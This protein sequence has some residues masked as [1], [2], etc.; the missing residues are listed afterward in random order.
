MNETIKNNNNNE[1]MKKVN[2]KNKNGN[3]NGNV[4]VNKNKNKNVNVNG[5]GKKTNNE[6]NNGKNNNSS[7]HIIEIFSLEGCGYSMAAEK[8]LLEHNIPFR[9]ISVSQEDKE[10]HKKLNEMDTFPQIFLNKLHNKRSKIGGYTDLNKYIEVI[11][12]LCEMD[13][14]KKDTIDHLIHLHQF[15]C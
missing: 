10:Y 14:N 8:L 5:N 2:S 15:V 1:N 4:N 7:N 11:K 6:N 3:G 9:K 13:L 12:T